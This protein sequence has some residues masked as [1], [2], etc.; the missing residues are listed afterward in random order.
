MRNVDGQGLPTANQIY[1]IPEAFKVNPANFHN[2][3]LYSLWAH[4][5][6]F[7]I[8]NN[9]YY[10]GKQRDLSSEAFFQISGYKEN[11]HISGA[12][13]LDVL[14]HLS[15]GKSIQSERR[16]VGIL[17]EG[18]FFQSD[19]APLQKASMRKTWSGPQLESSITNIL[20]DWKYNGRN[21]D[22][23]ASENHGLLQHSTMLKPNA[24]RRA[25]VPNNFLPLSVLD[26]NIPSIEK[27]DDYSVSHFHA[28]SN[29]QA[30]TE[31]MYEASSSLPMNNIHKFNNYDAG[32]LNM[33]E[34]SLSDIISSGDFDEDQS[35]G[36]DFE[37]KQINNELELPETLW[38]S[39]GTSTSTMQ[40]A[41]WFECED[42][43][44]EKDEITFGSWSPP[45][46]PTPMQSKSDKV[47]N[48]NNY[49][50]NWSEN[51][52]LGEMN[53]FA[54][55]SNH[56]ESAQWSGPSANVMFATWE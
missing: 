2:R 49:A 18:P 35:I 13:R 45:T 42:Y 44:S 33:R 46:R 53:G 1:M 43:T 38:Q 40:T 14:I 30:L 12:K 17:E 32:D 5:V 55:F 25:S 51:Q 24:R 56:T 10:S 16:T 34:R 27:D 39:L 48:V 21:L 31:D 52:Q 7:C 50:Y 8:H 22:L 3:G 4:F 19:F 37:L 20:D 23:Q 54:D 11:P 26:E 36:K 29:L 28:Y 41:P 47:N 15:L 9:I 6:E